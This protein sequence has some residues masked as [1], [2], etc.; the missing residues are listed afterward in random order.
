MSINNNSIL[1]TGAAGFIGAALSIRLLKEDFKV[2]GID[3][4]IRGGEKS[5]I[6]DFDKFEVFWRV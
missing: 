1:I 5:A 6:N 3:N 2:I 4:D